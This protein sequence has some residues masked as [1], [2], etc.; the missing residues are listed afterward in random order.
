MKIKPISS[1]NASKVSLFDNKIKQI[2]DFLSEH[3]SIEINQYNP[4]QIRIASKTKK[5]KLPSRISINDISLHLREYDISH[6]KTLLRDIILSPNQVDVFNPI[7]EYFSKLRGSFSGVSHIDLLLSHLTPVE[8][9]DKKKGYYVERMIKLVRKWLVA[10]AA[11]ALGK[12]PN[13]VQLVFIMEAEGTGKTFLA[14]F[15]C[16]NDLRSMFKESSK[17]KKVFQLGDA[18]ANNFL[19]LFDEMVGLNNFTAEQFKSIMSSRNIELK[20][21]YN[22]IP[23]V[24]PRLASTIGT[25]NN[26]TGSRKGFLTPALGYRRFGCL[27]LEKINLA[28]SDKIDI[29][30]LWAEAL[31]ML[32]GGFDYAWNQDDFEEFA[33]YNCRYMLETEAHSLIAAYFEIPTNGEGEWLQ[34]KDILTLLIQRNAISKDQ[35]TSITPEKIGE[36]LTGL[37]FS[38]TSKHI[39]HV[40]SRRVYRVKSI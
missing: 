28:Y 5:Y 40:G 16:P 29:D 2:T 32:D 6:S 26:K 25:T 38:R 20:F 18:F 35:R 23:I 39:T 30:N 10:S 24:V 36:A 17:D 12:R 22:D 31:M 33:E 34:P 4:S 14:N 37:G 3:Y 21:R 7:E 1:S 11:C 13:D 9:P 8:F 15:L 19:V 27:H